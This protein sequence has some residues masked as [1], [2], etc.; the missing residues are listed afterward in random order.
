ML[1]LQNYYL[2]SKYKGKS[3]KIITAY[4]TNLQDIF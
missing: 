1:V 2:Y 4:F 3:E